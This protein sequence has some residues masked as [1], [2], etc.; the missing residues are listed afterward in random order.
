GGGSVELALV[1]DGRPLWLRSVPLGVARIGERFLP[2]DPPRPGQVRRLER[3][4][5]RV[6]GPLLH[7]ARHAGV[8]DVVGTSGTVNTLVAMG[9]AARGGDTG[10]LH[11]MVVT[12]GEIARLRRRILAADVRRRAE[13][14]GMDTKRVDLMP[15]AAVLVDFVLREVGA[16]ELVACGW[17]LREGVLLD[18][19]GLGRVR[20]PDRVAA[21]RRAVASL[22]NRFAGKTAHGQQV[23][24]IATS[25]FDA[26]AAALRLPTNARE[27]IEYA[28]VLHDIGHAIDHDRHHRHTCY[29]IRHADMPG[30][31]AL[32]I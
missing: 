15:P 22:A 10:R 9:R 19:A 32:E 31:D 29:L 6:I 27:L 23:A 1:H 30:F 3:H 11:G 2:T 5:M 18:L 13:L 21:R 8:V 20:L 12:A 17:A 28:A 25:L 14:P 4:L 26:T 16:R 7:D 24:R